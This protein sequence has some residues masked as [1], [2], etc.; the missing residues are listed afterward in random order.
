MTHYR[1]SRLQPTPS[2]CRMRK[3][4]RNR[5]HCSGCNQPYSSNAEDSD[6]VKDIGCHPIHHR[7][8]FVVPC[9]PLHTLSSKD[10]VPSGTLSVQHVSGAR[11][12]SSCVQSHEWT[13][14]VSSISYHNRAPPVISVVAIIRLSVAIAIIAIAIVAVAIIAVV[15]MSTD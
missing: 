7:A 10:P 6:R 11:S 14:I 12:S 13:T 9:D 4:V 1:H 8:P 3:E 5:P 2:V 15:A